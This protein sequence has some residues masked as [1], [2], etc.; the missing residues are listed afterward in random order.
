MTQKFLLLVLITVFSATLSFSQEKNQEPIISEA[1]GAAC[2]LN[3]LYFDVISNEVVKSK[4][5]IFIIFR[6]G[7]GETEIVN[8]RRLVYVK[9]FLQN[10]KGWRVFKT[11]YAR[12]EKSDGEGKIEFYIGGNLFL[13]VMSPKNKTPCLDCCDIES[14]NPQNLVKK[15]R[16]AKRKP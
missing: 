13:V 6:S 1:N 14:F 8:A 11:I 9:R 5:R 7:K 2:E 4:E 16:K 3:S 10:R 15:K 12:G